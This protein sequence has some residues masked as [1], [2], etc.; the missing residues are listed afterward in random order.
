MKQVHE[1]RHVQT[2]LSKAQYARL[3]R[4]AERR[5]LTIQDAVRDAVT[6]WVVEV[7]GEEDPFLALIGAFEGAPDAGSGHDEIYMED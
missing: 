6:R 3:A 1:R 5:G 4:A 2:A 7:G